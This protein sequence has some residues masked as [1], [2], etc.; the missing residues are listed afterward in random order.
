M[1]LYYYTFTPEG[2]VLK[3]VITARKNKYSFA[4]E[5]HTAY[6]GYEHM[7]SNKLSKESENK[8]L[9][10]TSIAYN[11]CYMYSASISEITD[12]MKN[13]AKK[14]AESIGKVIELGNILHSLADNFN[15]VK[16][17]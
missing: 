1:K 9:G 6:G 15:I 3:E 12:E 8:I 17:D 2:E 13:F 7:C 14:R 11:G 4:I 5:P 16:K 10:A